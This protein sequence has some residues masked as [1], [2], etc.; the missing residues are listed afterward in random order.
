MKNYEYFNKQFG[1]N[2]PAEVQALKIMIMD[3]CNDN[4]IS[5]DDE[6]M[7]G[8]VTL[9]KLKLEWLNGEKGE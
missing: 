5:I 6:T 9:F 3:L 1:D 7:N 8:Y 2:E 4:S